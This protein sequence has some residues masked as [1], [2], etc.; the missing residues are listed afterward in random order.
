MDKVVD[1]VVATPGGVED[2]RVVVT[3]NKVTI[4]CGATLVVLIS[5]VAA[6][7]VRQNGISALDGMSFQGQH[8][9]GRSVGFWELYYTPELHGSHYLVLWPTYAQEKRKF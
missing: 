3:G 6:E 4:D 5:H 8:F 2:S 9:T 7:L 1:L